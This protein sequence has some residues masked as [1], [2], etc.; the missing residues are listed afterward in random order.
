MEP[1]RRS[2]VGNRDSLP[3]PLE[4]HKRRA[5]LHEVERGADRDEVV[6]PESGFQFL[7]VTRA[8]LD[9]SG[10]RL[11]CTSSALRLPEHVR[12]G[13]DPD[14]F[15]EEAPSWSS[16]CP[17]PH[18]RSSSRPCPSRLNRRSRKTNSAG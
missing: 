1:H 12:L 13:V 3:D 9:P 18:P 10:I 4:R 7:E 17:V 14:G 16:S 6:V 15:V 11:R 5:R 8:S 2:G